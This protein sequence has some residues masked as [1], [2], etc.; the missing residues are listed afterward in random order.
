MCP[1]DAYLCGILPVCLVTAP[2]PASSLSHLSC[3]E[4]KE[5]QRYDWWRTFHVMFSGKTCFLL[6]HREA[7]ILHSVLIFCTMNYF[8][9][10]L[11]TVSP[12]ACFQPTHCLCR[13]T[14]EP[15]FLNLADPDVPLLFVE[16]GLAQS[17]PARV[18]SCPTMSWPTYGQVWLRHLQ[19]NSLTQKHPQ[20]YTI[21]LIRLWATCWFVG[22]YHLNGLT[23]RGLLTRARMH[24]QIQGAST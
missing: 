1:L 10:L 14:A 4:S 16:P 21:V 11:Q 17:G 5:L 24:L 19:P 3:N 20:L 7:Q 8:E 22:S 6:L 2:R 23:S 12:L 15:V 9:L 13:F 18:T